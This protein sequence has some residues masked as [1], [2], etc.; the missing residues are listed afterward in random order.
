M[1]ADPR[2]VFGIG[3]MGKKKKEDN[4]HFLGTIYVQKAQVRGDVVDLIDGQQRV[5]TTFLLFRA[6]LDMI[7]DFRNEAKETDF[8]D[9]LNKIYIEIEEFLYGKIDL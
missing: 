3:R 2:V 7:R 1:S 6:I 9:E 5:T 4:T 8:Y